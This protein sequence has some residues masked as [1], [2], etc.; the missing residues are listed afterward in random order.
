MSDELESSFVVINDF[1]NEAE[2]SALIKEVEPH[3]KRLVYEKDHWDEA[4][5]GFRETERKQWNQVNSVIIDKLRKAAFKPEDKY[6][7]YVHVLDLAEDGHIKPHIDSP[8]FCGDTVAVL[9]LLSD[10]VMKLVH[11]KSKDY[12]TK[13][14]IPRRS[15]YIMRGSSRYDFTHEILS[16]EDSVINDQKVMKTRRI[17]IVCRN[18]CV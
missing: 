8:R 6:L 7:P 1:I 10:S 2:E 16:N 11:E 4:I 17:S 3:L 5:V 18:E 9:S 15:L 13:Y 12:Q 14:L